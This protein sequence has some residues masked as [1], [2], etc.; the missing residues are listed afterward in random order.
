VESWVSET[1][2]DGGFSDI[3]ML[4]LNV[5]ANIYFEFAGAGD[6]CTLSPLNRI[7]TAG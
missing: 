3:L 5:V 1:E 7:W 2:I 6:C 4:F